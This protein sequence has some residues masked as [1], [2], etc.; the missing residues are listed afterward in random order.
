MLGYQDL[1]GLEKTKLLLVARVVVFLALD[2]E[3]IASRAL[4]AIADG[5]GNHLVLSLLDG[6]LVVLR[7]LAEEL[8]LDKVDACCEKRCFVRVLFHDRDQ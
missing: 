8:F 3:L 2:R 4:V 6:A 5:L 1:I 7:A